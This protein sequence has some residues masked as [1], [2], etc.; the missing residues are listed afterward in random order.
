MSAQ[1]NRLLLEVRGGDQAPVELPRSGMMVVGSSSEKAGLCL[2]GQGVAEV[3]CAIGRT[4]D[5]G[6]AIKDLGSEYGTI[7]NG[8]RIFQARLKSGDEVLVGSV[9]LQVVPATGAAPSPATPPTPTPAAKPKPKPAPRPGGAAQRERGSA[10]PPEI[11]GYRVQDRLGNGAMGEVYLAVQESLDREVALKMLSKKHEQDQAF[12][13]SF[14]AEARS[15]AALNHP[16]IV[17]VHDVGE[18]QGSHFLTMEY[19]DRGSL[20]ERV[21]GEGALPWTLVLQAL[22]DAA[23]GL[24]YAESRGIVHRDIKP[25]NLMQ[26]H[27]GT[28]KIAD[29]GLATSIHS[30]ETGDG[31]Q[32]IFGTPHFISPEQVKG[33]KAD[34]RSD[35][36]SLG[37][38]AY[39][40]LTGHTPF[41]GSSTREILRAKLKG[42]PAPI[43]GRAPDVPAGLVGIVERMME[44][45]P[46]DR[47]PS[48]SA[49]LR[50]IEVLRTASTNTPLPTKQDVDSHKIFK[51]LVGLIVLALVGLIAKSLIGGGSANS[52][53]DSH[54]GGDTNEAPVSSTAGS[55]DP[56]EQPSPSDNDVTTATD[57][58]QEQLFETAAE[59]AFLKLG[60]RDLNPAE[61]REALR[62][63]ARE[64]LGTTA[65]TEAIAEADRIDAQ[66]IHD[67]EQATVRNTQVESMIK[68]LTAAADLENPTL[69]P[70]NSLLAMLAVEGQAALATDEI[71]LLERG[72]LEDRVIVTA[73]AQFATAEAAIEAHHSAGQ[74]DPMRTALVDLIGRCDL[75][76]FDD[77]RAP[78]RVEQIVAL[79]SKL[80]AT[81]DNLDLL[82]VAYTG[83]VTLTDRR[84]IGEGL[85]GIQGAGAEFARLDFA[86]ALT[87]VEAIAET[88][89]SPE[90][91][92]WNAALA[93][94]IRRA[95]DPVPMLVSE[96][97]NW[98]RSRVD[99]PEARRGATREAVAVTAEGIVLDDK[100][101]QREVPWSAFGGKT[102]SLDILF[103][104]RL[105]RDYTDEE[106]RSISA[107][108]HLSALS[109]ALLGAAEM[110][111][112]NDDS[113]FTQSEADELPAA[114]DLALEWCQNDADRAL[115]ERDREASVL[116][117]SALS[118]A[119]AE[120]WTTAVG[121]LETLL[122]DHSDT[123]L[124][125]LLSDGQ[126][127]ELPR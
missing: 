78:A 17:T 80:S 40:L 96:F 50:E 97:D 59:N 70:G 49:L 58:I 86:A 98:R 90:A 25:A 126:P 114:F 102:N 26:N 22:K 89:A 11:P 121:E 20:E 87:R 83:E 32:K 14:Q 18:H 103:A 12:V 54:P 60:Q 125:R 66:L 92:A 37:S 73:L 100:G 65:S 94:H 2:D 77:R 76:S 63:L 39:R 95:Q 21:T 110:F 24:V 107:L 81:L 56:E 61:R 45:E 16:N 35:L 27:T 47:Y 88:L 101:S 28:T 82:Q 85:A 42:G 51:V 84:S 13:R 38:T 33:E 48:A 52:T 75:P 15:A 112:P 71:F 57:D 64:Y 34:C 46:Q 123:W 109:Q 55:S 7:V 36:Y 41:E 69:R 23:S 104:K 53:S 111:T 68:L 5:G 127:V 9:R 62:Q 91:Q 10:P 105:N 120:A 119:T 31:K 29:L 79:K 67:A 124:V 116:L 43:K 117:A 19:M 44:L 3:H 1:D 108:M 115:I 6:Y 4:K 113:V 93:E 118:N 99:D 106:Q 8:A 74:F 30:E 122:R 72:K